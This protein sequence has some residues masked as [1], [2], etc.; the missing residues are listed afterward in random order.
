MSQKTEKP[1]LSGQRIK[2]RKRDEKE[3]YDPAGFRDAIL[4]GLNKAG[5]DL[6][7]VSK[8]LDTAGSKLDYRRY[9]EALFDILIAGGLLVPGGSI[10][11]DGDKPCKTNACVFEASE[12]IESMRSFEQVF[13]KLMRRYK[14][15]EKMFEDEMKKVLIF[16]KGFSEL[17]RIK[18]ARMTALWISNGS[19]PPSVLLVLINEHLIKDNLALDFLLEVF[20]TWKQE[21]GLSS[22]MAA[23]KKGGI[24]SR[25]M[26]FVP[27]NKRTEEN[28]R[29]VFEEKGLV[30]IVKLHKAQASQEAKRDLQQQLEEQ[31]SEY[32][33]IKEIIADIKEM[34]AK[35]VIP[36]HETITLVWTTV[37][38]QVEWN[39]KEELVAEQALKHLKQYTPLFEAFTTTARSELAL[40]LKVQEY[41][42]GNMNF[43]KV[44]QKIILLFYKTDVLS[45]GVILK[46]YKEGHSVK[47]K[48][49]FLDQM[50]KFVEWLQNAE[51]ESESG[52]EED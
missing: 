43:M 34:A 48:M 37:M 40:M 17:E 45:E 19:V 47:G 6:E 13:I 1:V 35:S 38:S 27:Q 29:A 12:D 9:G 8:F 11:Q 16:I 50:K 52:E 18:L 3:K 22:L 23:L 36:E 31:L 33:P 42:Y 51:E 7:A 20:V 4:Q 21:K 28:F 46:W 41:C 5:T 2:T 49:M 14:Y 44:F 10:A 25:L 30:D 15:L 32:R 24:E 26:E 39:K